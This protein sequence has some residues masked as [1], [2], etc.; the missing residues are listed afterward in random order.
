VVYD[1]ASGAGGVLGG[2]FEV[3]ARV[4]FVGT[5][6]RRCHLAFTNTI[7]VIIIIIMEY[8]ITHSL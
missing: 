1:F 6:L 7:I 3:E 4:C 8:S 5:D 2:V